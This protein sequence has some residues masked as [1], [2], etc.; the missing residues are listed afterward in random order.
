VLI[1]AP[2]GVV[3]ALLAPRLLGWMGASPGVAAGW[4]YTAVLFGG[5]A[6]IF[7]LFLNNAIFRG[8][9]DAAIAMR[10]LWLSNLIN[11]CLDPCLIFGWGP[12]PELGLA[13]AAVATT[14]GRGIG[15]VFQFWALSTRGGAC[16]LS[17]GT[18]G[19]IG[20]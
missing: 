11:M 2:V 18:C 15:V 8:A 17:A 7:L 4:S 1:A 3:G 10:A 9:G 6:T 12:F 13:G 14:I 19:C 16:A 20:A 5:S